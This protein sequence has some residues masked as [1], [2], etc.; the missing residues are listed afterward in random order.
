MD[1]K[2]ADPINSLIDIL[3]QLATD[4]KSATEENPQD[5]EQVLEQAKRTTSNVINET[6]P[7]GQS[8]QWLSELSLLFNNT[9]NT[10]SCTCATL[11]AQQER[12]RT[13]PTTE[14]QPNNPKSLTP[15]I[16]SSIQSGV[17]CIHGCGYVFC[18][19]HC[20]R[21]QARQHAAECPML[22]RKKVLKKIGLQSDHELF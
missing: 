12:E 17:N 14:S 11:R 5:I 1:N 4:V 8:E 7:Q 22:R 6:L 19:A 18:S 13:V 21:L 2:D 16:T 15:P 10:D 20:R 3:Q 9:T